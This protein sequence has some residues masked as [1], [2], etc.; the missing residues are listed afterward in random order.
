MC[1]LCPTVRTGEMTISGNAL[2]SSWAV[3]FRRDLRRKDGFQQMPG[4]HHAPEEVFRGN[5][6]PEDLHKGQPVND[7]T[8]VK[9]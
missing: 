3:G 1:A 6:D 9:R 8:D 4:A 5:S 7:I 2:V